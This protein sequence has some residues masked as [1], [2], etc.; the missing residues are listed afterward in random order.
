MTYA[1]PAWEF[2]TDIHLIKLQRLQNKVL[3]T[4]GN[5]ARRTPVRDL[6]M[7]FKIPY[8]YDYITKL[9]RKQ[10]EVIQNHENENVRNIGQGEARH[11]KYERLKLGGGQAYDRSSELEWAVDGAWELRHVEV[12]NGSL[13]VYSASTRP[14][15]RLPLRHLSLQP[16]SH[17]RTFSLIREHQPLATLQA[18]TDE[19]Y[20]RWVKTLAVEL[21][22]QTPLEAIRFL[23]ILGITATIAARRGYEEDF[24]RPRK[25]AQLQRENNCTSNYER[26]RAKQRVLVKN[27]VCD[28]KEKRLRAQS[29]D[30]V[31][32]MSDSDSELEDADEKEVAA[33]LRKCQQVDNYV[34]VREK[35]R[36]FES[37]CRQGR[38]LAQSSDNLCRSTGTAE[39]K[40]RRKKRARSLHDLSRSNVAVR[41][42]CR[43]FEARGQLAQDV[44]Q[45]IVR[46]AI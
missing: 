46:L 29:S 31:R 20:E 15:L 40:V 28:C 24:H 33:L 2:A 12:R 37:L 7:A 6:C 14:E 41:E 13:V 1:S 39:V 19:E 8:V 26:G 32:K 16:A 9:C 36:L 5:F 21:M 45:Q 27:R 11:R 25:H 34:P 30:P 22:S 3:R 35:R 23:D 10:A 44:S 17:P 18:E 42:I 43:Y 4:F 38:R